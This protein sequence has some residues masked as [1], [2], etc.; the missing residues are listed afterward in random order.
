MAMVTDPV[1]GMRIDT[2]D[3]V[4]TAQHEGTTYYFCSRA[5]YDLFLADQGPYATGPATTD[6]LT[7][8]QLV[9]RAS[10]TPQRIALLVDLG[11]L[12]PEQG[13]FDGGD[14]MTVRIIDQLESA[15]IEVEAVSQAMRS[16][17]LS[18][19]YMQSAGRVHPRSGLSFA[20]AAREIGVSLSV[21]Q[22]L[23]LAVGLA[24]PG[25]EESVRAED[26]EALRGLSVF[27][28]A[29][30]EEDDVIRLARLWGDNIRRVAQYLS[31]YFHTTVEER[32]RRR[33]M[34]DNQAYGAA[35][36]HVALRV[37]R[38]G[39]DLLGWL[40]RRHSDI[41]LTEHQ[42]EHVETALELAGVR[43]R[44]PKAMS[45]AVFADLTGFTE[46]TEQAGDE[47]AAGVALSLA[48]VANET[49]AHHGGEVVKL[50]GDG[51]LLH[52]PDPGNAI[53]ASL[54]IV[55]RVEPLGLPP[56]HIGVQAGPML[57]EEGDYFGRT[58][59]VA[60]RIAGQ[61]GP[62]QVFVGET[63]AENA[64][65]DGFRLVEVGMFTLKGIAEEVRILEAV[66]LP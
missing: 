18:L 63:A 24:R 15:G 21:L 22:R 17:H 57:Y 33:G 40:F 35:L 31:H 58:V 55:E 19:G 43:T 44:P 32:Y 48:E 5:C 30:L 36:R 13:T 60:S 16:G 53:R 42:F 20:E 54:E 41:F 46:L 6:R 50:L 8:D 28:E 39:E 11:I 37:G 3:A 56:A 27:F 45:A 52:V 59:N 10:T 4:S 64:D 7:E 34:G 12:S 49:A 1:C 26:M 9:G 65:E 47:V 29:G 25:A 23:Y 2:A 14:V 38:S 61:A 51:V 66:R 62:G